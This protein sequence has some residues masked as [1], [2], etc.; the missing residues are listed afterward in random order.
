MAKKTELSFDIKLII[1]DAAVSSAPRNWESISRSVE[2]KMSDSDCHED[3]PDT[4]TIRRIVE[5]D[6]NDLSEEV[7]IGKLPRHIW[8]L[9]K[10]YEG[11]KKTA[12]TIARVTT[13]EAVIVVRNPYNSATESDI[14]W[15]H[16]EAENIA[17]GDAERCLIDL[18]FLNLRTNNRISCRGAW[19]KEAITGPEVEKTLRVGDRV[20]QIPVVIRSLR[21]IYVYAAIKS[22]STY[23]TDS[24]FLIG[25]QAAYQLEPDKYNL[26]VIIR[27]GSKVW[28]TGKFLL[29]IPISGIDRFSLTE[30]N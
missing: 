1:W 28:T 25:R 24:Q 7:V 11:I 9:R 19:V 10:D 16:V 21:E 5:K 20:S 29:T 3:V 15:W 2:R 23:I 12:E 6:I 22:D 4:R 30:R 14:K 18:E 17:G 26:S 13:A 8:P 27:S